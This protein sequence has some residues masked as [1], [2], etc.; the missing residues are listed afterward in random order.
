MVENGMRLQVSLSGSD[1]AIIDTL[2]DKTILYQNS[3]FVKDDLSHESV[4]ANLLGVETMLNSFKVK[5][6]VLKSGKQE[7]S[8]SITQLEHCKSILRT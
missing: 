8:L 5:R 2:T 4:I 3:M 7:S 6:N 1:F